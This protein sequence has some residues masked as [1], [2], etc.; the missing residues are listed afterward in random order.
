MLSVFILFFLGFF[1][2]VFIYYFTSA[3]QHIDPGTHTHSLS[4]AVSHR[5]L[6][7]EPAYSSLC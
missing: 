1:F 3:A 4:Y 5:G 6:S 2:L 7:Q